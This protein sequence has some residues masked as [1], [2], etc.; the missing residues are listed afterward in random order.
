[1][2]THITILVHQN[3]L[4]LDVAVRHTVCMHVLDGRHELLEDL[5]RN[6]KGKLME[7]S[8]EVSEIVSF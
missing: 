1:M 7:P 3:I 5:E 2:C 6:I 4:R 8:K